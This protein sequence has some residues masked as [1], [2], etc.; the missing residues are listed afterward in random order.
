MDLRRVGYPRISLDFLAG[1]GLNA[2]LAATCQPAFRMFCSSPCGFDISV[3]AQPSVTLFL[4]CVHIVTFS[5]LFGLTIEVIDVLLGIPFHYLMV[6]CRQQIAKVSR[7]MCLPSSIRCITCARGF[8]LRRGLRNAVPN[9]RVPFPR[10]CSLKWA[11]WMYNALIKIW[12]SLNFWGSPYWKGQSSNEVPISRS[13]IPHMLRSYRSFVSVR[14][15]SQFFI[16]ESCKY[17]PVQKNAGKRIKEN[18]NTNS[19]KRRLRDFSISSVMS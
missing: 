16:R 9:W 4:A 1:N 5:D 19:A 18:A 12:F 6:F 2:A 13:R 14:H 15:V 10:P 11:C 17:K 8:K 3:N 7:N